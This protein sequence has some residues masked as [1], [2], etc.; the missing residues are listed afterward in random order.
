[1]GEW[2]LA[3]LRAAVYAFSGTALRLLF[4]MCQLAEKIWLEK[5]GEARRVEI[6]GLNEKE[7]G[8]SILEKNY[9]DS[10]S[11]SP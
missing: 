10:S 4:G 9:G 5:A 7:E 11:S 8:C 3:D 6:W 2:V 1:M